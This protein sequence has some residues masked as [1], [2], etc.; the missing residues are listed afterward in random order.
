MVMVM[1]ALITLYFL[2]VFLLKLFGR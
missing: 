2:S 1:A